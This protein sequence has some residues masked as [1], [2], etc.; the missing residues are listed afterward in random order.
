MRR[1]TIHVRPLVAL[2]GAA[3]CA[4]A[5]LAAD[6]TLT[7]TTVEWP[8]SNEA[9]NV[10]GNR[11]TI[12]GDVTVVITNVPV[13]NVSLGALRA[14]MV[15]TDGATLTVDFT[16]VEASRI[17]IW[18][19]LVTH[20]TGKIR[21]RGDTTR[22]AYGLDG[23]A[24]QPL[25]QA[26]FDAPD[27]AFIDAN[28]DVLDI[29]LT[30][31]G[32]S[33]VR[34]WPSCGRAFSVANICLIGDEGVRLA[35]DEGTD[36]IT[37]SSAGLRN[38][39]LVDD[40]SLD[41]STKVN[42][43]TGCGLYM[44]PATYSTNS[45]GWAARVWGTNSTDV[46]L[47]G[48][49]LSLQ[50]MPD[51]V[52]AGDITGTG[53]VA[54]EIVNT[55]VG[56]SDE[57]SWLLGENSFEG[58]VIVTG[59]SGSSRAYDSLNFGASSMPGHATNKVTLAAWSQLAF[60][61]PDG[62]FAPNVTVGELSAANETSLL[63]VKEG[64]TVTINAFTGMFRK[65]GGGTVV[66]GPD[67]GAVTSYQI[68]DGV[69]YKKG[70]SVAEASVGTYVNEAT[71]TNVLVLG[72]APLFTDASS[73]YAVQAAAGARVRVLADGNVPVIAGGEGTA[74]IETRDWRDRAALWI[75]P[76]TTEPGPFGTCAKDEWWSVI[77]TSI[78]N[79]FVNE[80]HATG[81]GL[82]IEYMPDCRPDRTYYFGRNG[83]NY[84]HLADKTNPYAE[85][86]QSV[87]AYQKF[88]GCNGLTTICCVGSSRRIPLAKGDVKGDSTTSIP[89]NMVVMVFGSHDGG[90]KALVGTSDGAFARTA[91][92]ANGL[93]TSSSAKIWLD[94]VKVT[95][96]NTQTLN[97]GW[98]IVSIDTTGHD[99]NGFGWA[100]NYND[101]GGQNYGEILVFTNALSDV[102]RT[103]VE[104]Y[105]A[106]KWG[107]ST[108]A[109]GT[110]TPTVRAVGR[111]GTIEVPSDTQV[112]LGGCYAGTVDV[113]AGAT[114]TISE[115]LPPTAD[116]LPTTGRVGWFDP[117][118][119]GALYQPISSGA[120]AE[121]VSAVAFKG[122]TADALADGAYFLWAAG[123]RRPFRAI[124][125]RGW[126]PER[127]WLDFQELDVSSMTTDTGNCLRPR[128]YPSTTPLTDN[129]SANI[130]IP[131]RTV[132][133]VS[134][135]FRG[136]GSPVL[137]GVSGGN[138]IAVRPAGDYKAAIWG[139]GT[140]ARITG[141]ETRLNGVRVASP[142]E[143][144][145]TGA[146]EV[147][148][149]STTADQVIGCF[150]NLYN[151]QKGVNYGEVLGEILL[152]N[153]VLTGTDRLAVEAYLMGKWCGTLPEGYSDLREATVTGAGTVVASAE[154]MPRLDAA[155]AGT[156]KVTGESAVFDVV[157]DPV[158]E[159]V[160]GALVATNA[161]LELPASAT[162]NASFTSKPIHG[163]AWTLV[164]V[165]AMSTTNLEW[166]VNA[167][168]VGMSVV[169][170]VSPARVAIEVLPAGTT[171][172]FR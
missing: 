116:E 59:G 160:T 124:G 83:R 111:T 120:R 153:Q 50:S 36:A 164:D 37:L 17:R 114:L 40:T 10:S 107:I 102:E 126:G 89:A 49:K 41:P 11:F 144:G 104:S 162:I 51:H 20:G 170:T 159:T 131:C 14:N 28:G 136:G 158:A 23:S 171:I 163:G 134:D 85:C 141:G 3:F 140:H 66:F 129:S 1:S 53:T 29:P 113:K 95:S 77:S 5:A 108:Y 105:L 75:D 2:L 138:G 166:T 80:A 167:S 35:P 32:P 39:V 30:F 98:Q 12:V 25:P 45:L 84:Q 109:G 142:T 125:A 27:F 82:Y 74:V 33:A 99:V 94:G 146:P 101:A 91:G 169:K 154:K 65:R 123:S 71:G 115:P 58:S 6:Y 67:A 34:R 60:F 97:G 73:N 121:E 38:L 168:V 148:S 42:V 110:A 64:Q 78:S 48:G 119:E 161:T 56:M 132:F 133:I 72:G 31:S 47:S 112:T 46:V 79:R 26:V 8:S 135:S 96:P 16:D 55:H 21:M 15:V 4:G 145:F 69:V 150:G 24:V 137:G 92:L 88:N 130:T 165:G 143:T 100:K 151:T 54:M 7:N 172:L 63:H 18:G 61:A 19:T 139:S 127:A 13:A 117:D 152:Y 156:A 155:F 149:F 81:G 57:Y 9:E 122:Q 93:T 52:L 68:G 118:A 76:S 70:D 22:I 157:I 86:L 62:T 128:T 44:K 90:G 106:K 43:P 147:F 87:Y 103:L